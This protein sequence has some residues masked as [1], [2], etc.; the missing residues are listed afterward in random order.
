MSGKVHERWGFAP[1][2]SSHSRESLLVA[3]A[4]LPRDV[5]AF[6][7]ELD[8]LYYR[9][10]PRLTGGTVEVVPLRG[11][12]AMARVVPIGPVGLVLGPARIE[13]TRIER[14][15][16]SGWLVG[17][18]S[19]TLAVELVPREGGI[20]T[21]VVLRGFRPRLL[22]LPF[23]RVVYDRTQEWVHRRLSRGYLRRD[24]APR[25]RAV[26]GDVR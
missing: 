19:G 25:L 18:S 21:A 12:G 6:L 14:P 26:R 20:E 15:I 5:P 3:G 22:S 9:W 23:G 13:G 8:R 7:R 10:I 1:D 24:V 17:A 16:L 11:G 4:A 2:G